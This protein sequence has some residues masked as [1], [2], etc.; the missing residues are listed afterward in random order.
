MTV[1]KKRGDIDFQYASNIVAVKWYDNHS[2]THV[3]TCLE[4]CN[5]ISSIS[6]RVKG[7]TAKIP[8]PCPS[9]VKEYN[10]GMGFVDL[11]DQR[12][13]VYKLDRK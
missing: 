2:V 9:I 7:K 8:V 13:A 4:G 6:R 12:A 10:N 3:G 11:L 5:Q 1:L